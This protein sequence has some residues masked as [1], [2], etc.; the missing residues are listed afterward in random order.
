MA[1]PPKPEQLAALQVIR[2]LVTEHGEDLGMKLARAQFVHIHKA[3]WSRWCAQV[4]AEDVT[5]SESQPAAVAATAGSPLGQDMPVQPVESC[6]AGTSGIDFFGQLGIMLHDC[7]LV[8][9]Y[10]APVDPATGRRK[11]RN[12]LMLTQAV[13]LRAT[14]MALAQRHA[15]A[16]WDVETVRQHHEALIG[17]IGDAL[18]VSGDGPTTANILRELRA[19]EERRKTKA[20]YLGAR[21]QLEQ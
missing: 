2:A 17:A 3:T 11:I 13:K 15:E 20:R 8:R 7:D 4:R 10:A 18:K 21:D 14:V 5:F 19:S 1:R 6:S 16:A 9:D 12:P